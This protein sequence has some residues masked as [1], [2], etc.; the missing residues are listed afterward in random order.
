VPSIASR[1]PCPLMLPETRRNGQHDFV[2]L[3]PQFRARC[4][5]MS[6]QAIN[7]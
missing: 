2:I 7:R 1:R 4:I 3:T 5:T 6:C